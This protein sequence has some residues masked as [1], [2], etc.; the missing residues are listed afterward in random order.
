MAGQLAG[1]L[2]FFPNATDPWSNNLFRSSMFN[3][4]LVDRESVITPYVKNIAHSPIAKL[5]PALTNVLLQ[6]PTPET[7]QATSSTFKEWAEGIASIASAAGTVATIAGAVAMATTYVRKDDLVTWWRQMEDHT[8]WLKEFPDQE[9]WNDSLRNYFESLSALK[10]SLDK[11]PDRIPIKNPFP[12]KR[13]SYRYYDEFEDEE[14]QVI[15]E[16][17]GLSFAD[18]VKQLVHEASDDLATARLR[19]QNHSDSYRSISMDSMKSILKKAHL[20][21]EEI[22]ILQKSRELEQ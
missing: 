1:N 19:K 11:L 14:E 5:T 6:E 22:N 12:V 3:A 15:Q 21:P 2:A 8:Y 7:K 18:K 17:H 20:T 13:S 10:S 4:E 16:K 9:D